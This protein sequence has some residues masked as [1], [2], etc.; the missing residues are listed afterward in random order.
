MSQIGTDLGCWGT[1]Q[2]R[3]KTVAITVVHTNQCS[4]GLKTDPAAAP[5]LPTP[6]VLRC[7][8]RISL[9]PLQRAFQAIIAV[10]QHAGAVLGRADGS[11]MSA[12]ALCCDNMNQGGGP[13]L[14]VPPELANVPQ[15]ALKVTIHNIMHTPR[16][17]GSLG[18]RT[19]A[20]MLLLPHPLPSGLFP[21][22]CCCC[23]TS[24]P[25]IRACS[26]SSLHLRWQRG[27]CGRL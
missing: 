6:G 10:Q 2:T 7:G 8:R 21:N 14:P 1:T 4:F 9:Q 11:P 25:S 17:H 18:T 23:R 5:A 19:P 15:R 3:S 22:C 13:R 26:A 20:H 16:M 27:A 12:T 24:W